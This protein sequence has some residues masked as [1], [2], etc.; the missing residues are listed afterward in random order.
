MY[1][2]EDCGANANGEGFEEGSCQWGPS[3]TYMTIANLSY[4]AAGILLCW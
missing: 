4:L 1:A 2:I 3:A